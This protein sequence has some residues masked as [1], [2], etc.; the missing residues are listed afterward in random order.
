MAEALPYIKIEKRL[1]FAPTKGH[2]V[3]KTVGKTKV[4]T[5]YKCQKTKSRPLHAPRGHRVPKNSGHD[6]SLVCTDYKCQKTK[7]KSF[8]ARVAIASD[9]DLHF[10]NAT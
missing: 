2:R 1:S 10:E 6:Q 4:S 7:S 3:P 9:V 8:F 5:Y